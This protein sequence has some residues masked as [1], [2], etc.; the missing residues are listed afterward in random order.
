MKIL[1]SPAKTM[2]YKTDL[3]ID[4]YTQPKFIKEAEELNNTLKA[5]SKKEMSALMKISDNLTNL[6]YDR[7]RNFTLPFTTENARPAVFAFSGD[8]YVGLDAYT[9]PKSKFD[10]LQERL[11]ILSGMYGVLRPLD[12][13]QPYRLEMGTR[14]K[15]NG[16]ANLYEYWGNS[17]TDM[18]N[19]EMKDDELLVNLASN[20][21]FKVINKKK[22]KAK[23]VTPIF[24]DFKN[25]ELK[26]IAFYAKK[27]RGSMARYLVE[28]DITD[29]DG[30]RSFDVDGYT[31]SESETTDS[32][33]PVFI[34]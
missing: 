6:N 13:M 2:D 21:Y 24:K 27:A 19:K 12:L 34:R 16:A 26:I 17:L 18:L 32:C 3:P 29:L 20:E 1:V 31:F 5:L 22:L 8:V 10:L 33:N 4:T 7:V 15:V 23:L 14:L 28:N 25:G 9:L 11:R 30:I